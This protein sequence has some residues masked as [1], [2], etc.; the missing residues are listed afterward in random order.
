MA[1]FSTAQRSTM[2][3]SKATDLNSEDIKDR[4]NSKHQEYQHTLGKTGK[5]EHY[6]RGEAFLF[7][8]LRVVWGHRFTLVFTH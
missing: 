3:T 1:D 4:M 5:V 7:S 6:Q 2:V 8:Y